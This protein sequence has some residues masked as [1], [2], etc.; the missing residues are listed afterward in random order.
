MAV[1]LDRGRAGEQDP[2]CPEY[3]G[4][5]EVGQNQLRGELVAADLA[6]AQAATSPNV[7]PP[8]RPTMRPSP[9]PRFRRRALANAT[10]VRAGNTNWARRGA[11][12]RH[13]NTRSTVVIPMASHSG[14][15]GSVAPRSLE[16]SRSSRSELEGREGP[17]GLVIVEADAQRWRRTTWLRTVPVV[18]RPA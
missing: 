7:E 3:G 13:A 14:R 17:G 11:K 2:D 18:A 6:R 1:A 10:I 8:R 5:P 16:S 12:K 15:A 9:R 4:T